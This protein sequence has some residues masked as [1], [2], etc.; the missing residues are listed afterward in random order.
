MEY[1]FIGNG[2]LRFF[3]CPIIN[4]EKLYPS[5]FSVGE[6]LYP[7][8][9]ARLGVLE[10]IAIKKIILNFKYSQ[11]IFIYKDT[12]NSLYEEK[13]LCRYLEAQ[14]EVES[15][16]SYVETLIINSG[17]CGV[18]EYFANV[19]TSSRTTVGVTKTL[20]KLKNLIS[21]LRSN[22]FKTGYID[23]DVKASDIIKE[24]D[25]ILLDGGSP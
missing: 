21:N 16:N 15:F 6:V 25:A 5:K 9:K 17:G 3:G 23:D 4:V 11:P 10:K 14:Q 18:T 20:R 19:A 1:S 22:N 24:I 8:R 7:I 12:F 2:K 13:E